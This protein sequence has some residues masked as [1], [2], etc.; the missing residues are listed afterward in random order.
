M[1]TNCKQLTIN[2]CPSRGRAAKQWEFGRTMK[3]MIN[4]ARTVPS[5]LPIE[6]QNYVFH[7]EMGQPIRVLARS[8][9][10][11]ASTIMRQIRKVETRRDDPLV[12][13]GLKSLSENGYQA[14]L[15]SELEMLHALRRLCAPD[16]I[17][18]IALTMEHGVILQAP[19]GGETDHGTKL[20]RATAMTLALRGWIGCGNTEARVL[21]Y[22]ITH[23]GRAAL[24]DL[25]AASENQARAMAEAPEAFQHAPGD[26]GTW[27]PVS[28]VTRAPIQESPVVGLARRR[29]KEGKPFLTR[30]MVRAAERL[31]ED[32]ELAQVARQRGGDRAID[33]HDVL[34][35]IN[36][37]TPLETAGTDAV[38]QVKT[39][40]NFLGPGLS[41]IAVRCCCFLEGL[42][43]TEKQMGWAARSGK[44]V[45]RIALQRLVLH[46]DQAG[47]L[48]P[49]IG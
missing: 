24:R 39:A 21:R 49:K 14:C 30:A 28:A 44:I 36:T 38:A 4:A 2:D 22:R 9:S 29:D 26:I 18:A 15:P 19:T 5:W 42:E 41:E 3:N 47:G 46:Y 25:T 43:V 17:L 35:T 23:T 48:G 8:Q 12:D 45:L 6:V 13:L 1:L 33:W 32:F 34:E 16:A 10:C 37:H 20:P 27:G 7:T 31:R 40:L 11:H